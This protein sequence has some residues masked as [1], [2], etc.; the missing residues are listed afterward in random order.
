MNNRGFNGRVDLILKAYSS[1]N[2][3]SQA[4]EAGEIFT[5]ITNTEMT[6]N[7]QQDEKTSTKNSNLLSYSKTTPESVTFN[8]GIIKEGLLKLIGLKKSESS[9][10]IPIYK[11]YESNDQGEIFLHHNNVENL[12]IYDL[13]MNKQTGY[14]V[15]TE[16][17]LVSGL[18]PSVGLLCVYNI[19]QPVIEAYNMRGIEIPYLS[20]EVV[21]TMNLDS[22]SKRFKIYFPRLALANSP[23]INFSQSTFAN[24]DLQFNIIDTAEIPGVQIYIY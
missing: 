8:V 5:I 10:L 2:I 1:G 4:Y 23:T 6:I 16:T 13:N 18:T 21:G 12:F 24:T 20:A 9:V 19:S 22:V 11:T 14:T 3:N 17:G 15:D 7:Y